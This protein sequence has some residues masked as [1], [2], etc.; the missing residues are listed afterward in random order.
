M[1]IKKNLILA[2]ISLASANAYA[3]DYVKTAQFNLGK[4]LET[5]TISFRLEYPEYERLSSASVKQLQAQGFEAQNE[6]DFH[7]TRSISRGDVIADVTYIPVVKRHN[8]W[9]AITNYTLQPTIQGPKVSSAARRIFQATT[10]VYKSERYAK[11]SVLAKGKWVK[12]YVDKEGIY[13][14]TDE[15]LKSAGFADPSKVKLYGYGGRLIQENLPFEGTDALI[16]DL[17]EVPLYRRN[18]SVL[19]F[20]EGLTSYK[21]NTQFSNNTFSKHSYYFL[22]EAE[23]NDNAPLQFGTLDQAT[24]QATETSIV[25][26]HGLLNNETCVWYGGGRN[27]YD[28]NDLQSG[29]TFKIKLPGNITTSDVQVVYDV[30]GAS[31]GSSSY[32]TITDAD[33]QKQYAKQNLGSTSEGEEA[34]GYHSSFKAQFGTEAKLK[35]QTPAAGKLNYL[36]LSY[37]QALSV[38]N[39]TTFSGNAQDPATFVISDAD[40]NT[41]VWQIGDAQN[42]CAELPG[43]LEGSTYK[44]TA[45]KGNARFVI[46]DIKK[47]YDSPTIVGS[48]D[49]QNLHA[50]SNIDYIIIVPASGTLTAQAERLA[51]FH[52]D[53]QGLRVKVVR[54]DQIYNEFSS[55]TPDGSAYRRYIKMLYDRADSMANAPRYL[56]LFGNCAYDNRMITTEWKKHN[57][58]DYLLAY[59]RSDEENKVGAYGIGT[60]HD[61]VTDDYYALLDDGEGNNIASEKIDLGVGRFLCTTEDEA[62]ILVD[63]TITYITN[64]HVGPWKNRMWAIADVGNNNLHMSDAQSV[65]QQTAQ[66]ADEGFMVRRIYPDAYS[67]VSEAKGN[68]YPEATS[69][70]KRAM[71]QGAL[72]FNYN[73]HG[74]PKRISNYFLLDRDE[75]SSNVS[76]ALPIWIFAS[77]EITPYDQQSDGDM[78]RNAIYNQQGGAV[79]VLCASRSVYANYNRSLNKGFIKYLFAKDG[80]GKR[81]TIGDALRLTKTE[82][83]SSN[84]GNTIGYD[85]S[86]NKMKYAYFGDPAA[87]LKYADAGVKIDSI[88]SQS[89]TTSN[90]AQLEAGNVVSFT[91][92]IGTATSLEQT[93]TAFTGTLYATL[94]APIQKITC[95][96]QGNSSTVT[97]LTYTDYTQILFEGSVPVNNG[98]FT[99]KTSIPRSAPLSTSTPLLSLYAVSADKQQELCGQ[100][101]KFNISK[102]AANEGTDSIAPKVFIYIDNPDFPDG[103]RIGTEAT[104]YATVTDSSGIS[105]MTGSMGHD[106]TL[107]FDNESKN[108]L[109]VNDYFTFEQGS[110]MSGTL[111]Y[112]LMALTPGK[113]TVYYRVWDVNDNSTLAQLTFNVIEN[114]QSAFGVYATSNTPERSTT[115]VTTFNDLDPSVS[116]TVQTEV[117]SIAGYRVWHQSTEAAAGT[118]NVSIPWQ[119]ND[120]AGNKLPAGVYLYRSKVSGKDTNTQKLIIR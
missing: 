89:A 53:K 25:T 87:E 26:A 74:S 10:D 54:A 41:R 13:Q 116:H 103:G 21:S 39:T 72:I 46:V 96:G 30:T 105:M 99:I 50:D 93:D 33:T 60:I 98:Q 111:T 20:A 15:Q 75:M 58:D 49:N 51:D 94:F 19:F 78:G 66:S 71:Q 48:V 83:V 9:Y 117:Y 1:N 112:P 22:T 107:W 16:D 24:S 6:V 44:A 29:H 108:S 23:G 18:G 52:R 115:F 79:G 106:M 104:L 5:D 40:A 45:A 100:F 81:Y 88:N 11:Q 47:S 65:C 86:I 56:L 95:K 97:P 61:Y 110:Y 91:G 4:L 92:H 80:N 85:R 57:P 68:T 67:V 118:T 90:I 34:R 69:K 114:G 35:I 63:Q 77:C 17:N 3:Q 42:V 8:A 38:A 37:Q 55:G 113:H 59:E 102:S 27:F 84:G 82:L 76:S 2:T 36:Y 101:S 28:S 43:Q 7:I 14:L 64:E 62:K 109:N 12:M 31:V 73:G 32:F 70:L 120:Y 119:L